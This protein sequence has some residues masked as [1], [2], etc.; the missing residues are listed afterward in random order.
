[1]EVSKHAFCIMTHE[2][3]NQLQKQSDRI[4]DEIPPRNEVG[5]DEEDIR[6][7]GCAV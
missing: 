6:Y 4:D 7:R 3:W 1:M 2:K 5:I